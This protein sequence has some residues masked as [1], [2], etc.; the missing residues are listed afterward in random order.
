MKNN[1]FNRTFRGLDQNNLPV[2]SLRSIPLADLRKLTKYGQAD[3]YDNAYSSVRAISDQFLQIKVYGVDNNGKRMSPSP[4]A[5]KRISVPNTEQD[6]VMFKDNLATKT[7]VYD[8]VY[9]LVHEAVGRQTRPASE[10]VK[11]ERIAGYTFL[12]GVIEDKDPATGRLVYKVWVGTEERW[13]YPYQVMTFYD[14]NP[15]HVGQ[16][17]SPV[18]A[19][20]RWSRIED[21][22][23]D[24]E[25]GFFENG[26][27]PSG[28]FLITAPT[29]EEY[30]N[31]VDGL[32]KHHRGA[33]ANNNVVYTYQPI[34]PNT[35]KPAQAAITW[36]P[37][38]TSNKDLNLKDILE[39]T[40]AKTDSVYRVSAMQRAITDAPNFATA[41]VD[42]RNFIEKTIRPFTLKK[43]TRFQHEL[44]RITGGLGYGISFELI[45][46]YIAEEDKAIAET[47]KLIW[48]TIKD[49]IDSGFTYDSACDALKLPAN[50]K[51]LIAGDSTETVIDNE[52][53]DVVTEE[54]ID[55][56]PKPQN[57]VAIRTNPKA[58][59][60]V[61]SI[62]YELIPFEKQIEDVL[63]SNMESRVSDSIA[64]LS[65]K[66]YTDDDMIEEIVAIIIALMLLRGKQALADSIQLAVDQGIP[67][68][69]DIIYDADF[70]DADREELRGYIRDYNK[71]TE[72]DISKIRA[73]EKNKTLADIANTDKEN[74]AT[75]DE[76]TKKSLVDTAITIALGAYV[77]SQAWRL[78]RFSK[79]EAW[80]GSE[81]ASNQA[82]IKLADT[83]GF[84]VSMSKTWITQPGA[85]P[86]CTPL[87]GE[88]VGLNAQFSIG[89]NYPPLHVKCRCTH[90]TN[91][92]KST[93]QDSIKEI[94][95]SG[96]KR[97]LGETTLN[98]Y[99]DK[100]KCKCG[101]LAIP[102]I[103][104]PTTS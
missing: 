12:E 58:E 46:P 70:T 2:E 95:C 37:F 49:M 77:A 40:N 56:L 68:G 100:I 79:N 74:G 84:L 65:M 62:E 51:L 6:G 14:V 47:H 44:N 80:R 50:W 5:V 42:D 92:F 26:A 16:G 36:V 27:V 61:E 19:A 67:I 8:K 64:D 18:R 60:D 71:Q 83:L 21:Y 32:E 30:N 87:D 31:V 45:T 48:E 104:Q 25:S 29:T 73:D 103:E 66:E 33:G 93:M 10:R 7:Q 94:H 98:S 102:T 72:E 24:Y 22:I 75:T 17:Y 9:V 59:Y 89:V 86:L 99:T 41:Q 1:W 57:G 43:W 97:F 3:N 69:E 4:N 90:I 96:C 34:D 91:I 53:T 82:N 88:T 54:D 55:D 39:A 11:E 23:A 101:V 13:Y 78:S 81:K 28:Q 20:K 52:K 85:C 35:G 63:R 15:A 76:D 38:N